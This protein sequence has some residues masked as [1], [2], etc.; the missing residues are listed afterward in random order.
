MKKLNKHTLHNM[1]DTD[2]PEIST[3]IMPW[4]WEHNGGKS[5][6]VFNWKVFI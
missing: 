6:D 5:Q 3:S 2:Y 4:D 1:N